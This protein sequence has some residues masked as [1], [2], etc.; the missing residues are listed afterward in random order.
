MFTAPATWKPPFLFSY[1]LFFEEKI[2]LN[3]KQPN[4][5]RCNFAK[6]VKYFIN[7][8]QSHC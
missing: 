1:I 3:L 8:K 4:T 2:I 5:I 6:L 7:K